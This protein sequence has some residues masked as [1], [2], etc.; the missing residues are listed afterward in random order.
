MRDE[1]AKLR[2]ETAHLSKQIPVSVAPQI[3]QS[4]GI[5]QAHPSGY[6]NPFAAI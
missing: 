6:V 2:V 3:I 4:L 1:E 5:S